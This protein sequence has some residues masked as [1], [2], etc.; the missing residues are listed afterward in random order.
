MLI[1]PLF[2]AFEDLQVLW[3][4][5]FST[6]ALTLV[7]NGVD[8]T[9]QLVQTSGTVLC[10]RGEILCALAVEVQADEVREKQRP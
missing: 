6:A 10:R 9:R 2:R 1:F 3:R 5:T 4:V 8:L 7:N